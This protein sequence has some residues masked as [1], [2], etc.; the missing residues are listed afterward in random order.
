MKMFWSSKWRA[1]YHGQDLNYLIA[2]EFVNFARA[3]SPG[4][5]GYLSRFISKSPRVC[6]RTS[7]CVGVLGAS[8]A[9][10]PFDDLN[11]QNDK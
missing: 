10:S 2:W 7:D 4:D 8:A 6:V 5:V 3:K 9:S 11:A 1:G